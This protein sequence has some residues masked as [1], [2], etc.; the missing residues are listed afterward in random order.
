MLFKNC[1]SLAWIAFGQFMSADYKTSIL[2]SRLHTCIWKDLLKDLG[3]LLEILDERFIT[4]PQNCKGRQEL[5][6]LFLILFPFASALSSKWNYLSGKLTNKSLRIWSLLQYEVEIRFK[7][8]DFQLRAF[9]LWYGFPH[10][11]MTF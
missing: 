6:L 10:G 7:T 11:V 3:V 5:F 2:W 1:A 8:A 4:I 9:L